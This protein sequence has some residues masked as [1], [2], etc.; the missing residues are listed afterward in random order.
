M[1]THQ[2]M[3]S[4]PL[5]PIPLPSRRPR[6]VSITGVNGWYSANQRNAV[7]IE[8]VGTNPLPRNGKRMNGIGRLLDDSTLFETRP[9]VTENQITA[10]LIMVSRPIAANHSIGLAEGRNPTA[11]ATT[12]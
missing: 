12:V 11:N 1:P 9:S 4:Q 5:W 2:A 6:S 8:S 10:R 7:G 3:A